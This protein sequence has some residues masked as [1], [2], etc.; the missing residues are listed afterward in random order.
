MPERYDHPTVVQANEL[1]DRIIEWRR[2]FHQH[3]ELSFQ[4]F[5]TSKFVAETLKK[6]DGLEVETGIGVETSVVATLTQGVGPV[7]A[8][9]ADM[10]ALPIKEENTHHFKS[11]NEGIMHACGHD[12]H[13]SILLGTAHLLAN[14]FKK[15]EL[16]GTIKFIFQPAEESTDDKG[17]S[18]SPY[19]VQAGAYDQVDAAIALHM[20]PWLPV[21]AAQ[22]ND[23]YSMANVDVFSAKIFGTGGH[24]AY[25]ELGTDPIWMLGVVMQALHG[26]V[27]RKIPALEAGVIS[28]GQIHAGTA[29]NII[30]NEVNISGTIR[31]YTPEVRDLLSAELN[32]AL[33]VVE[34][35]GGSFTLDVE[36]G[37]PALFNDTRVNSYL[38]KS[39]EEMYPECQIVR[40]PFG[41]GGE[42]FGYVTQ[43]L[44]GALFFLGS[45]TAD[46]I[47]R[48]L[49][50]PI[51]DI[52]ENSLAMGAAILAQ[53]AVHFLK[54]ESNSPVNKEGKAHVS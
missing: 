48:D 49:H 21:G 27:A 6:I 3:P 39:I 24:G 9:R 44:P 50:T 51:F 46:G 8:I 42:D 25:P 53:T 29:S 11:E 33:S 2:L 23:G 32:K 10:D 30:P 5:G 7:I 37:E 54:D 34:S 41:M 1:S 4:E 26:I 16:K 40:R 15:E 12:A 35:L 45:G 52:D 17:L 47:K 19:M 22:V 43:K 28:I 20:C 13:T 14:K 38:L 36:R 31:S 18:G